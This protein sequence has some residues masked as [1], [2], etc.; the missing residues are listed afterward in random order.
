MV[1]ITLQSIRLSSRSPDPSAS[2]LSDIT[3]TQPGLRTV[4]LVKGTT[5]T[6][7]LWSRLVTITAGRRFATSCPSCFSVKET[8]TTS[9]FLYSFTFM[10]L[11]IS[12]NSVCAI[13]SI[14]GE[15]VTWKHLVLTTYRRFRLDNIALYWLIFRQAVICKHWTRR[16]HRLSTCLCSHFACGD[17]APLA[18]AFDNGGL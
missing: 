13:S 5:Q 11:Q 8:R 15:L 9:P 10:L 4:A 2:S 1:A 7:S 6:S 3:S 14:I 17:L 16:R 12:S 18:L